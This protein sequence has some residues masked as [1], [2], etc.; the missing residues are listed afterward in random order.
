V[1]H[2]PGDVVFETTLPGANREQLRQFSTGTEDPNPIH[3]DEEFARTAGFDQVLQQGPM[4]TAHFAR[5]LIRAVG[6]DRL[7]WLDMSF[8]APVYPDEALTLRA[9]ITDV[10]DDLATCELTAAKADGTPTAKGEAAF[11]I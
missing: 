4:T 7:S 5:L 11:Q 2:T 1:N 9:V 10:A 3:I 6:N 8:L